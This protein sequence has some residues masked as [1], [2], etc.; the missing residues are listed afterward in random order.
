MAGSPGRG[1][2]EEG[3][4][5]IFSGNAEGAMSHFRRL[6]RDV[7]D[8]PDG[9]AG[10]GIVLLWSVEERKAIDCFETALRLGDRRPETR[11][12]MGSAYKMLGMH[13]EAMGCY[14]DA[15]ALDPG[16]AVVHAQIACA[17]LARQMHAEAADSADRAL[18]IDP[19]FP[20]AKTVKG[21]ALAGLGNVREGGEIAA[22]AAKDDPG[23]A[24]AAL[25]LAYTVLAEGDA[26]GALELIDDMQGSEPEDFEGHYK[27]GRKFSR[28]GDHRRAHKAY[29]AAA[30]AEPM[31][32]THAMAAASLIR[33]H[34]GDLGG[35]ERA[36]AMDLVAMGVWKYAAYAFTHIRDYR[37]PPRGGPREKPQGY[38]TYEELTGRFLDGEAELAMAR[39]GE[40]IRGDPLNPDG[41]AGMGF[42]LAWVADSEGALPHLKE[43]RKLG[44]ERPYTLLSLGNAYKT[45]DM[46]DE[47][48]ECYR[49]ALKKSPGLAP[50]HAN[51]AYVHAKRGMYESAA[52][53]AAMALQCDPDYSE[54]LAFKGLALLN[55]GMRKEADVVLGEAEREAPASCLIKMAAGYALLA[56]GD[57]R[58]FLERLGGEHCI[59]PHDAEGHY[60][61]GLELSERGDHAGAYE[62]YAAAAKLEP[63]SSAY[64]GMAASLVR[65]HGDLD[66]G[67][68][69]E[70][71]DLIL[72][73]IGKDPVYT[74]IHL[75]KARLKEKGKGHDAPD[76]PLGSRLAE[77]VTM[78]QNGDAGAALPHF[79]ALVAD[80]PGW[81]PVH[82]CLGEAMA[83]SGDPEGG[84]AEYKE[85]IRLGASDSETYNNM[86]NVYGKLGM[87]KEAEECYKLA[88]HGSAGPTAR[89]NLART[90]LE[91]DRHEDALKAADDILK[92]DPDAWAGHLAKGE[93]LFY[94][95]RFPESIRS[96]KRALELSPGSLDARMRLAAALSET[97]RPAEAL[98]HLD[99]AARLAPD[100]PAVH[101]E[102]GVVLDMLARIEESYDAYARAA[103]LRP[104]PQTW[105]NMAVLLLG[106][107]AE[108]GPGASE[109][110]RADAL[111][112]AD[113]ALEM[114]PDYAFGH[115][116][117][118]RLL[119]DAGRE[120]E[121]D[122]HLL[123]ARMLDPDF[124]WDETGAH[125]ARGAAGSVRT[126][127]DARRIAESA[128]AGGWRQ[129]RP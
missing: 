15:L 125:L 109:A 91:Q 44:D 10:M 110:W 16:S 102:R 73:A 88:V 116:A 32:K 40:M 68:R 79:R 21:I 126:A 56:G 103:E 84:L 59:K 55:M 128:R 107:H 2:Y 82:E 46:H 35:R 13:D 17:H 92:L 22:G 112:L 34:G 41:H 65:M 85:A 23:S 123:H 5:K 121:A 106:I 72:D 108:D 70:A 20:D 95:S 101:H 57:A 4:R 78:L 111:A 105:A 26:E 1:A 30:R 104:L 96:L 48:M 47:A 9:H 50:A 90:Y 6:V 58:G 31:P 51:M 98:Q 114:D 37:R 25:G 53:S 28:R 94:L 86:A 118:S 93:A 39:F 97:N 64:A 33:A 69:A 117:K 120:A 99:E 8:H 61:R 49:D 54:A 63:V 38:E 75:A 119:A 113:K 74:G 24:S 89:V 115:F 124:V 62:A 18:R 42:V 127:K 80:A 36:E 100:N 12:H 29:A 87:D 7:P 66:E 129:R 83:M 60:A 11:L 77:G 45:L 76:N 43:A 14:R 81:A 27:K 71:L 122:E 52:E 19:D 3:M 67:R